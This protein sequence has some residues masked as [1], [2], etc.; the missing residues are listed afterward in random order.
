MSHCKSYDKQGLITKE[1]AIR[2]ADSANDV[3][4]Q[5]KMHER[6]KFGGAEDELG[7]AFDEPDK[8]GQ[9]IGRK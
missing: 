6:G 3:R 7:L 9:F 4:L 1:E 5:I 8:E 2:Y